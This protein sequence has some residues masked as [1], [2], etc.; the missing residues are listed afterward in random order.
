MEKREDPSAKVYLNG[1]GL[2]SIAAA[3]YLIRK[4]DLPPIGRAHYERDTK[5]TDADQFTY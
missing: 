3:M 2:G 1:L 4:A 5:Y